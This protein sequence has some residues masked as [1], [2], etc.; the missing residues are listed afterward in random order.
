[1]ITIKMLNQKVSNM[2]NDC[3]IRMICLNLSEL[4]CQKS[5][6]YVIIEIDL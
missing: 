5:K 1:M 4:R 3:M 6:I 2:Q